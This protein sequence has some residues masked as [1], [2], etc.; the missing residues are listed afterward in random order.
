MIIS[1]MAKGL[2][3]ITRNGKHWTV[4]DTNNHSDRGAWRWNVAEDGDSVGYSCATY[5]E[6]KELVI[7]YSA[8]E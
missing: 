3:S 2:Y 6:A 5:K 1:R 7:K 4:T 8:T